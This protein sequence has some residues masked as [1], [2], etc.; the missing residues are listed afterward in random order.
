MI[1]TD[2]YYYDFTA[3]VPIVL[4]YVNIFILCKYF[5]FV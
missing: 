1:F 5:H 4:N 2:T 3:I